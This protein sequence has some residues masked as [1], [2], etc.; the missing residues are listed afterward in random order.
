[1][2]LPRYNYEIVMI[3]KIDFELLRDRKRAA[4]P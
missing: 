2:P 3:S 4:S 1:L